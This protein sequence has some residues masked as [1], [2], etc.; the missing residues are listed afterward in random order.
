MHRAKNIAEKEDAIFLD[1]KERPG[2][3]D[4]Y[5]QKLDFFWI[6]IVKI[7]VYMYI[8]GV[9]LRAWQSEKTFSTSYSLWKTF[10]L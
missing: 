10:L 2:E 5:C 4:L 9:V 8:I 6:Y 7:Y 3:R 1:K